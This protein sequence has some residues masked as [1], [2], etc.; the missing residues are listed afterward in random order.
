MIVKL[1]LQSEVQNEK[2][3]NRMTK[4]NK[5]MQKIDNLIYLNKLTWLRVGLL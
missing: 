2:I 3:S 1:E 5:W 4:C